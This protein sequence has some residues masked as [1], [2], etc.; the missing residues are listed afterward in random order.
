MEHHRPSSP[1]PPR[2]WFHC[3]PLYV[4]YSSAGILFL[5]IAFIP[6]LLASILLPALDFV[7]VTFG[8]LADL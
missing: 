7:Q 8:G 1:L 5:A 3:A 6:N 2:R 4:A